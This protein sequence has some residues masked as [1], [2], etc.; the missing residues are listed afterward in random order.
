[1]AEPGAARFTSLLLFSTSLLEVSMY[2]T[3]GRQSNTIEY[4]VVTCVRIHILAVQRNLKEKRQPRFIY[5]TSAIASTDLDSHLCSACAGTELSR[6][7]P[8]ESLRPVCIVV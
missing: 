4:V 7:Q 2:T 6:M 3:A 8:R 5:G 1:M